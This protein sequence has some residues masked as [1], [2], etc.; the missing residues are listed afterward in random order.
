VFR[1]QFDLR[2]KFSHLQR[3]LQRVV[4]LLLHLAQEGFVPLP[5]EGFEH[6]RRRFRVGLHR[7]EFKSKAKTRT[8][9]DDA[10]NAHSTRRLELDLHQVAGMQIDSAVDFHARAA[11][12]RDQSGHSYLCSARLG[13]DGHGKVHVVS[14][15]APSIS[16]VQL[17]IVIKHNLLEHA[18]V[19]QIGRGSQADGEQAHRACQL[20]PPRPRLLALRRSS[21]QF[22]DPSLL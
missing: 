1:E 9:A 19:H 4:D 16:R 20:D 21:A 12:R 15:P 11:Y 6:I 14:G 17:G 8:I 13:R 22:L 5:D 10:D 2:T 3:H 18:E 7:I